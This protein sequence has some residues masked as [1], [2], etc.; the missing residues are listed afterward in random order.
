MNEY[1]LAAPADFAALWEYNIAANADDARWPRWREQF[2]ADIARGAAATLAA[3]VEGVPI[4]EVT[5]LFSPDCRAVAGRTCLA[6]GRTVANLNALRVRPAFEGQGHASG[7][8]RAAADLAASRGYRALTIG[9]EARET[10]N[11]AIYLHWGFTSF[12]LA[13]EGEDGP[14]LYY[15]RSLE[16]ARRA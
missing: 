11:L 10:R 5:L 13:E 1:R 8:I 7:L 15:R 9:V 2:A 4:G 16:N 6:D 3:V 12:V 14:I